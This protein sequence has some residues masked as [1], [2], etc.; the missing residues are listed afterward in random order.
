MFAS[1][2]SHLLDL[3]K[4]LRLAVGVYL[5]GVMVLMNF[6]APVF[7]FIAAPLRAALP[8][9]A[10]MV[11]LNAP[12]V[13]FTYLKVALL[14]SLFVTSPI[15]FYQ[16][17]AFVAPGLYTN[18]RK[19]FLSYFF[20]SL[21]LLITGAVFAY[22]VVLPLIFQFF[23]GFATADIQAFPAVKE[24]LSLALKLMF[25]FAASFQ[26][27]VALMLLSRAELMNPDSLIKKRRYVYVWMLVAAA[28]LTPPDIVSQLLLGVPMAFLFELGLYLARIGKRKAEARKKEA[29]LQE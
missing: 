8:P 12:D 27:P 13:F 28:L 2:T 7:D 6:S 4:R 1:I 25:A 14:M 21:V 26:I 22:L 18:E 17:W 9:G 10:P 11:F 16:V 5:L 15:T 24:Y 29:E 19:V 20:A 23:M 3:K